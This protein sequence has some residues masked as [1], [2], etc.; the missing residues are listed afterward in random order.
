MSQ[1]QIG[2]T[3]GMSRIRVSRLLTVGRKSGVI[4]TRIHSPAEPFADLEHR[5]LTTY[6]LRDARVVPSVDSE[7]EQIATLAEGASMWLLEQIEP[8]D[9]IGFGLGRTISQMA[10]YFTSPTPVDCTFMTLEGVGPFAEGG[11]A[12]YDITARLAD[13]IGGS[14]DIISAPTYVSSPRIRD[15]LVAE[16]SIMASLA[17]AR[18]ARLAL[19]SVGTVDTSSVLYQQGAVSS[20]DLARLVDQ[21]AV[22]DALGHFFS[23]DGEPVRWATDDAKIGLVLNDLGSIPVSALVAGGPHKRQAIL[24]A[25]RGKWFNVVLTDADTAMALLEHADESAPAQ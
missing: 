12:S 19:Q 7:A 23:L 8:G 18:N 3:L 13:A 9:V 22:G 10:T 15:A 1:E 11:F 6:Q 2:E 24:G 16:P 17:R 25:L 5:L 14:V 20:S 4:E 21:G